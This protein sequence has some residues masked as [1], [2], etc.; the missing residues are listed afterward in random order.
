MKNIVLLTV[1]AVGVLAFNPKSVAAEQYIYKWKDTQGMVHYT[2]RP[3]APGIPYERVRRPK[4]KGA[5][6]QAPVAAKQAEAIEA[7]ADDS[8]TSWKKENCKIAQQNLDVLQNAARIAQ[9]DGQGGKRLMTDEE[10]AEKIKQMNAQV[11]KYCQQEA[12]PQN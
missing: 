5:P 8:Y 4:D 11:Q 3:P 2:E 6:A 10:K 12:E 1:L 9:D 7:E